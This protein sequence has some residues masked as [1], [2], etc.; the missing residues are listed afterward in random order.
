MVDVIELSNTKPVLVD[1]WAPW[2]GPCKQLTPLLEKVVNESKGAIALAKVNVDENPQLAQKLQA[3]SLP[4]VYA[5]YKRQ[6]VDA[7]SG[8]LPESQ[9]RQF[10]NQLMDMARGTRGLLEDATT[11]LNAGDVGGAQRLFLE[12]LESEPSHVKALIGLARCYLTLQQL[13]Q[14]K[15]V[16]SKLPPNSTDLSETSE[17]KAL[18]TAIR[19]A[20]NSPHMHLPDLVARA[21]SHP[22]DLQAQ[23]DLAV[24]YFANQQEENGIRELLEIV[25]INS[26]WEEG[27]ARIQ[28]LEFFESLGFSHPLSALGRKELSKLLF[29]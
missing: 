29:H 4:M 15:G 2:C 7:F 9:I 1:L 10:C 13:D 17:I 20:E 12:V 25:R 27:K 18:A 16:F 28:L 24:A 8:V 23:F 11:A 21:K 19:L 5:F 3:Q 22:S 6:P 14:A 26:T